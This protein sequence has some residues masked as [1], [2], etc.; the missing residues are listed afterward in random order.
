[1]KGIILA[2]GYGTRLSPATLPISKSLLPVFD[3]PMIYYPLSI[4]M[5]ASIKDILIITNERDSDN[6]KRALGDGSQYG[7]KIS[8]QIQYVQ[9]GIS[10]AFIIAEKWIGDERV[11]LIL[12]DNIFYG[13]S[14]YDSV[15]KAVESESPAV[16]FGYN[17]TD[18]ERFGVVEF[19][20]QMKV[21]SIEEK[22]EKPKSKYAA[23]GL[24]FY[25]KGVC[26]KAKTLKESKRGELEITD[27]NNKYLKNGELSVILLND[28]IKW[29]D[30][31]TFTSIMDASIFIAEKEKTMK[32]KILCPEIIA[33]E[34]GFVTKEKILKWVE[35]NNTSEYF[36]SIFNELN[37]K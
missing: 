28:D 14:L 13:S 24:Y 9:R 34:K 26:D 11:A 36:N 32:K 22:P 20:N 31:G 5:A 6:F 35:K 10:D 4:L 3:R 1:M 15:S 37:V 29:L 8:Y 2:A 18:P 33:Y 12:G 25:R 19:D 30:A 17:V 7:I 21:L 27:L 16:I 23:I